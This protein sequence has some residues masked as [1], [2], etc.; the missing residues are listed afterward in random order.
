MALSV[1]L[2]V[3]AGLMLRSFAKLTTLDIGFDRNNV[4]LVEADLHVA[5]VPPNR[6]L[7]TFDEIEGRLGAL[8][9]V[10]PIGRSVFTP[11]SH[12]GWNQGIQ[13][14]LS[15]GIAGYDPVSWFNCVS[16]GLFK[17][18]R[19]TMLAG[20]NFSGDDTETSAPVAIINQTLAR[21][22]FPDLNRIGKTFRMMDVGSQPMP[23]IEVIGVVKDA[24][25]LSVREDAPPTAYF[26]ATQDTQHFESANFQLRAAV[27]PS[28]LA[29]SIQAA[30][31]VNHE[32][33]LQFHTLAEQVND[34]LVQ[35]RLLAL[36]SGFFGTLARCWRG[37]DSTVR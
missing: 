37:S 15:K 25:Y 33:P 18:L 14:E 22:F 34:S 26:P 31:G 19:I 21:R 2:L 7:A 1:V 16:P 27:P 17:T 11:I 10:V 3:A 32:I 12:R 29:A 20:R 36:L 35:E 6:Q 5:K 24:K 23:P 8:P 4:L 9:G 30:V 13:T 28:A